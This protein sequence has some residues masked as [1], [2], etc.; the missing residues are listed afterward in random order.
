MNKKSL[1]TVAALA[2]ALV[3][4][5]CASMGGDTAAK[6]P[7][8][9]QAVASSWHNM[10]EAWAKRLV[11]DETQKLCSAAKDRPDVAMG[12]KIEQ[13]NQRIPVVYPADG[14]L[15]GDWREG[16]KLAQSGYGLRV[17]DN[18]PNRP[19]GG[20]CYACHALD[21]KEL[22]FGTI[23]A[24]LTGYAK[25]RGYSPEMT[26]YVYDKIYNAQAFNACSRMPRFGVNGVLTPEQ[27]KHL[28]ALLMD[29]QSPVNQ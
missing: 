27:I 17:G 5:G 22:S 4:A 26:K 15:I 7:S 23:G 6:F 2:A 24:P 12:K 1:L 16:E 10:D 3:V 28:V 11:Q 25:M 20:N 19:N 13:I 18:A 14:K 9:E 8:A 21:K 29:P